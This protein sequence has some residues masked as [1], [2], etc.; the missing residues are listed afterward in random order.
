M[1]HCASCWTGSK[2]GSRV[3]WSVN[4]RPA[5]SHRF[6]DKYLVLDAGIVLDSLRD[7]IIVNQAELAFVHTREKSVA[8]VDGVDFGPVESVKVSG[9]DGHSIKVHSAVDPYSV[10]PRAHL[11]PFQMVHNRLERRMNV[12]VFHVF[13]VIGRHGPA[14][15]EADRVA[16]RSV[17]ERDRFP[18]LSGVDG[19]VN[20]G[21]SRLAAAHSSVVGR[22]WR[23]TPGNHL[24]FGYA[25][26]PIG[27]H[28]EFKSRV[29]D[30][31][32]AHFLDLK[33]NGK[34][35][36][37]RYLIVVLAYRQQ[38]KGVAE[39]DDFLL[40][41]AGPDAQ[42]GRSGEI[43]TPALISVVV[44]PFLGFGNL[45]RIDDAIMLVN[46]LR[47]KRRRR[48]SGYSFYYATIL[49]RNKKLQN[50]RPKMTTIPVRSCFLFRC[51]DSHHYFYLINIKWQSP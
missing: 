3:F 6:V 4:D 5:G 28:D 50:G 47:R 25:Q 7:L 31:W 13:D 42:L 39:K 22:F 18:G 45:L 19:R 1:R 49:L 10:D 23:Q 30:V 11:G 40:E 24:V 41:A 14:H 12:N 51:Y 16:P 38:L 34:L 32:P 9:S 15:D 20:L 29:L 37:P 33:K 21:R 36:M 17:G 26:L 27:R 8:R 46:K 44:V 2:I 48:N 43:S 35:A